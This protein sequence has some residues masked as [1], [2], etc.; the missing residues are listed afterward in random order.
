MNTESIAAYRL[1]LDTPGL[2]S[3]GPEVRPGR[4]SVAQLEEQLRSLL[5]R[6]PAPV[7]GQPL[8]RALV[9]LWHDH[10]EEAH[11]IAQGIPTADGSYV[12]AIMHRREPDYGNARY[13]FDRV[14]RHAAF[15]SLASRAAALEAGPP[16]R[17]LLQTLVRGGSW[18]PFAFL[19]ACELAQ[20]SHPVNRQFL[21]RLQHLEFSVLLEQ[22]TC[23]AQE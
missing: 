18:D 1:L 7:P 13:W 9:F 19:Q 8:L 5:A 17:R 3:L 21:Q 14:G 12:H 6:T 10:L 22:F 16:E 15:P 23:A 20:T 4:Q 11:T 2:A